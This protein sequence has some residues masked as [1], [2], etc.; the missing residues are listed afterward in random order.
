MFTKA[1][2][3]PE[4]YKS[5]PCPLILFMIYFN[6][7][8]HLCLD[9]PSNFFPSDFP[10]KTWY[11]YLFSPHLPHALPI[12]VMSIEVTSSTSCHRK[13][14]TFTATPTLTYLL[15]RTGAQ[16]LFNHPMFGEEYK[17]QSSLLCSKRCIY[18]SLHIMV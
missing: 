16:G 3:Y 10:T 7:F 11:A 2:P 17:S 14:C 6:L 4:P 9:L 8:S 1:C 18:V 15:H 13:Y 5:S 12:L